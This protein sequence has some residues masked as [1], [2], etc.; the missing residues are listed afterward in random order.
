MV[1]KENDV[2]GGSNNKKDL[3]YFGTDGI[4]GKA[5]TV[6]TNELVR[7]IGFYCSQILLL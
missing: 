7:K 6:L 3:I 5:A 2:N 4:R 1:P